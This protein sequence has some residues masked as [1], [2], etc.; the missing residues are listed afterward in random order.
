MIDQADFFHK[1]I[2]VFAIGASRQLHHCIVCTQDIDRCSKE[3]ANMSRGTSCCNPSNSD[4]AT[5]ECFVNMLR[6]V[7]ECIVA[8]AIIYL[9]LISGGHLRAHEGLEVASAKIESRLFFALRLFLFTSPFTNAKT[10]C[11]LSLDCRRR[12]TRDKKCV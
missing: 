1:F 3:N 11:T 5:S 4:V 10:K 12:S 6:L 2:T 7:Q 8:I 9:E